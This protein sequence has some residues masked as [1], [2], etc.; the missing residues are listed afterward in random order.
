MNGIE[1]VGKIGSMALIRRADSDIDYNIFSRIGAELKPGM[2]WI[3]SGATEI[4]RLDY[5]KR[6]GQEL[7]GDDEDVKTDY[8]AQG[9]TILM[10]N[11]RRYIDTRYSVRQ[12]LVEHNHFNDDA[13]REHIRQF[14]LRCARQNAIPIVNYNDPVS[15]EENRKMELAAY[16]QNHEAVVECVDNDETA[17]VIARTVNARRLLLLTSVDGIYADPA[18]PSTL[19]ETITGD[20][21][22]EVLANID[23]VKLC[24]VGASRKWAGGARAKLEYAAQAVQNGTE[25]IIGNAR[26]RISQVL[27]GQV[28]STRIGVK[29]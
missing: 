11:Y 29:L 6:A 12:L 5:I 2:I 22:D 1:L 21:L 28:P 10:E 7:Q 4:G 20:D 16:R 17:A 18:D 9:Q 13:K 15:F 26:Y 14:L 27:S 19:V 23:A 24:C 8:A 25:V 3:S